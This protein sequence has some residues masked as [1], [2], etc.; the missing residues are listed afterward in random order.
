MSTF[1]INATVRNDLGKGASRRLR[2][3]EGTI[4]AIV[5]GGK[6]KPVSLSIA[7]KDII[8]AT[9][10]EAFFSSIITLNVEGKEQKVILKDLQ[11]HPAKQQI[12]HADFQRALKG[13]LLTVIVP[14]HFI[15]EEKSEAIKLGGKATHTISQIEI[16]CDAAH[17]PEFIEVDMENVAIGHII[18]L[19]ELVLPSGV[20]IPVLK[21]GADHDQPVATIAAKRGEEEAAEDEAPAEAPAAAE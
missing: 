12:L 5:Y 15:N 21:L 13:T 9:Q 4:P 17:L 3:L 8:K 10:S 14:L 20:E 2:R 7:H 11:R 6:N 16:N 1:T 18:H 19:S